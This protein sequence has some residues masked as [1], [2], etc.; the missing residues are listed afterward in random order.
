MT[1]MRCAANGYWQQQS[2]TLG[3]GNGGSTRHGAFQQEAAWLQ[4]PPWVREREALSAHS[5]LAACPTPA[6]MPCVHFQTIA[7]TCACVCECAHCA[8]THTI[9]APFHPKA[10]Q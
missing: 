1:M 4:R 10:E 9:I 6:L 8:R 2:G 3:A 7:T 5:L